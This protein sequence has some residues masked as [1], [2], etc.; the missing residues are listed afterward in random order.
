M[1][2]DQYLVKAASST[3]SQAISVDQALGTTDPVVGAPGFAFP[4]TSLGNQF[5]TDSEDHKAERYA[6]NE[7]AGLFLFPR[8]ASIPT[9]IRQ[10]QIRRALPAGGTN[11]G[12][13]G[14]LLTQLKSGYAGLLRRDGCTGR[15]EQCD[16]FYAIGL[17]QDVC[18]L[19]DPVRRQLDRTT[20]GVVMP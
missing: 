1:D 4:N 20:P 12:N 15:A 3:T 17:W 5:E 11:S 7:E 18:N 2:L 16:D 6:G 8:A 10:A 14:S 13:Q 9:R 19:P